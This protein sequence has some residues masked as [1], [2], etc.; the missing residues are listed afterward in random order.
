MGEVYRAVDTELG[1][2]VAVKVLP[3]DFADDPE[4][5]RRFET[6]ARAA[7]AISHPNILAIYDVGRSDATS[8]LVTE[9][10]EGETLRHRICSGGITVATAMDYAIQAAQGPAAA[11]A[12]GVLHRDFK[13]ENLF[14]TTDGRI[15][16]LDFGLAKVKSLK[17]LRAVPDPSSDT[18]WK[19]E[20]GPF[21]GW[22]T[23]PTW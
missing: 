2:E 12:K 9:L 16:I 18:G 23:V 15:K 6:E 19:L 8:Y 20:V 17:N 21:P 10:L 7:A 14:L 4:R 5:V 13:T 1:R 3:P 22:K 11:H